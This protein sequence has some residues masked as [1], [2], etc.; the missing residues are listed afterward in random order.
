MGNTRGRG[1]LPPTNPLYDPDGA[2]DRSSGPYGSPVQGP[3]GSGKFHH[4]GKYH[5][6]RDCDRW[7]CCNATSYGEP[8]LFNR[9]CTPGKAPRGK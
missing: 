4:P 6:E 2:E 7:D 3:S 8:D 1:R 9:G 5:Q